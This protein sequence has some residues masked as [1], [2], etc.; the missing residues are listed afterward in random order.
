VKL[1]V[2]GGT[3]G[4]GRHVVTQ[5]L[6]AGHA[7]TVLARDGAKVGLQHERLRVVDGDV[8]N[9]SALGE[10]MRE[11]DAV[12]SA[13]GRGKSFKSENLIAESVPGIIAQMDANGVKRLLFM[14]ALGVGD[15]FRDSPLL[16]KIFF[17][18]LLRGVYA[19][20]AIGDQMIRK[21]GLDWTIV[22]PAQLT[23]SPLT[24]SYRVGEH[25][26]LSGMPALS[27]ADA[28]HFIIDRIN[29]RSTFG[30]TLILAN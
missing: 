23:D 14:S 5:A 18:T 2:L 3:G 11:Q 19:D 13:I 9:I 16:P 22:Q 24:K 21:S 7:V 1:L 17:R 27:R 15:T 8:K 28:A 20:K 26:P 12:L 29:D 10:A 6:D 30:K 4:T 25:L